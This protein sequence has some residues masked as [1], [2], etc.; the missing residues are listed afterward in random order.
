[1]EKSKYNEIVKKHT[2]KEDRL[3]NAMISFLTG[4]IMG[5]IGEILLHV[6]SY[7]FDIP[8][9]EASTFM[10]VTLIFIGCLFTCFGFFDKWVGFAK[11]G[12]FVPITG[13]AHAM[14][15]AALD[16]RKE[17]FVTGIGASMLKLSGSV[18]IF[19]VVSAYAFGLVRLIIFGG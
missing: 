11:A 2:P 3:F 15:S 8:T 16:F 1:M 12:L 14:M 4:G 18:I 19:G 6:Y 17:G 13:F 10:I 7:Y 9:T 5:V